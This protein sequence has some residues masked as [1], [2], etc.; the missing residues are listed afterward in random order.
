MTEEE[1]EKESSSIEA[2]QLEQPQSDDARSDHAQPEQTRYEDLEQV[3]LMKVLMNGESFLMPVA[4]VAEILRPIALTPVPMAPDHMLGL[5]NIRGQIVCIV[6]PGKVLHLKQ[7]RGEKREST[8]YL[9]L[10]HPRMHLGVWVDEVS[11]LFRVGKD[12][13]AEVDADKHEFLRGELQLDGQS[14][15]VLN[16]QALFD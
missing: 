1:L 10:R 7:K 8:R 5:A 13:L 14:F 4:E 16:V 15:K 2:S 9:I 3:E 6:D 11:E 12:S